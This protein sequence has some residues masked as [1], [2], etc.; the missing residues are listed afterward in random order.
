MSEGGSSIIS[1]RSSEK[2]DL[3]EDEEEKD[4]AFKSLHALVHRVSR[5]VVLSAVEWWILTWNISIVVPASSS[6]V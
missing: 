5:I 2:I 1:P 6:L 4:E 3:S